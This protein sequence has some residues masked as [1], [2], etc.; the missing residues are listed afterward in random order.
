MSIVRYI[1]DPHFH[2]RNMAIKRGFKDE[3]E[4]ND[5]IISEWNKVVSKK[6]V[7]LLL[8]DIT[9]EKNNYEILNRLNGIK[10]VILGNHDK[11]QHVPEL[12]K[13]VNNVSACKYVKDK[14]YGNFILTHIP[15]NPIELTYRFGIN[16]HGHV[17]ENTLE[18]KRYINVSAEV[19][20]YRPKTLRELFSGW[21][22][23]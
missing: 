22:K 5:H 1:S 6:D 17:H 9:M 15:I 13:Y 12:L 14:E 10:K 20:N 2:H 23:Y 3:N 11:P 4:M 16:I 7:T 8:G 21:K 18:D 19:I